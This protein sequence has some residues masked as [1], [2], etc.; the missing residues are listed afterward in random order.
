MNFYTKHKKTMLVASIKSLNKTKTQSIVKTII[1]LVIAEILTY[2]ELPLKVRKT[3]K[4]VLLKLS[5]GLPS[6]TE[7]IKRYKALPKEFD[8]DEDG[9]EPPPPPPPRKP[10]M[11]KLILKQ[12]KAL[13]EK[14]D[15]G[16]AKQAVF[17]EHIENKVDAGFAKTSGV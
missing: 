7:L 5:D 12:L 14:V 3:V 11:L 15:V 17:N 8:P 1:D 9:E 16:F 13:T 6:L 4:T 10:K 2:S